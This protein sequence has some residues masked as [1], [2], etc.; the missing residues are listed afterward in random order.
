M[1]SRAFELAERQAKI[2]ETVSGHAHAAV[3]AMASGPAKSG[4]KA[5]IAEA[6]ELARLGARITLEALPFA[7][8]YY[9]EMGEAE[10]RAWAR[11][12]VAVLRG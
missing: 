3:N 9:E 1:T 4:A 12:L 7:L 10:L 8:E 6:G 11:D 5:A 2:T